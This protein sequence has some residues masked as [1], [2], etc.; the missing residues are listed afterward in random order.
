MGNGYPT[1]QPDELAQLRSDL[2]TL[3]DRVKVLEMPTGT[4]RAG[5]LADLQA[6]ATL[7]DASSYSLTFSSNVAMT[8][9]GES[10]SLSLDKPRWV[11][12]S[13][14]V[15]W[16]ASV[17]TGSGS[18][19]ASGIHGTSDNGGIVDQ[20]QDSLTANGTVGF[21]FARGGNITGLTVTQLSAGDHLITGWVQGAITGS[22]M[23]GS[24]LNPIT[25]V[26]V[27]QAV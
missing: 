24:F 1:V 4:Q 6:R 26:T 8:P 21:G 22:G 25:S 12:I 10:I 2:K 16:I 7:V 3:A 15:Q 17:G 20:D 11:L 23:F 9:T 5:V 18:R 27:L 19:A 14:S 13:R